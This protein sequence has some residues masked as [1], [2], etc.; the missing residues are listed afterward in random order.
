MASGTWTS[1]AT[2]GAWSLATNWSGSTIADG[3]GF[4]ANFA[5]NITAT[6]TIDTTIGGGW[7]GTI[8]SIVFSD[9][10]AS[11]SAWTLGTQSTI[12]LGS[13][14]TITTT[15]GATINGILAG[16]VSGLTKTGAQTLT[17]SGVNTFSGSI[18]INA[19]TLSVT[20]AS[21]L[22]SNT[23][24]VVTVTSG[25]VLSLGASITGS[26]LTPDISGTGIAGVNDGA[27]VLASSSISANIGAI[28]LGAS[29]KIRASAS[30][31]LASSIL[32]ASGRDL[33][34]QVVPTSTGTFSGAIT[35]AG[36]LIVGGTAGAGLT[37]QTGT[38]T[39]SSLTNSYTG[40]TT[41]S[42]G[43]T[44][45]SGLLGN[46]SYAGAI[47][48]ASGATFSFTSTSNQTLSGG[49]SGLGTLTK[50]TGTSSILTLS[51]TNSYSVLNIQAGTVSV[52]SIAN[53]IGSGVS[54]VNVGLTGTSGTLRY[55]GSGETTSKVIN[56]AG[57]TTGGATIE[58][59]GSGALVFT[60][61]ITGVSA[62]G[63]RTLTLSGSNAGV[64]DFQGVIADVGAGA[65]LTAFTKAGVGY[66]KLSGVN[67]F[68]GVNAAIG[69]TVTGGQLEIPALTALGSGT[70]TISITS[71]NRNSSMLLS[72]AVTYPPTLSW[73]LSS[74]GS[75]QANS[76]LGAI[77]ASADSTIAGAVALTSPSTVYADTGNLT[78]SG[79]VTSTTQTFTSRAATGRTV[80]I[81]GGIGTGTA[82]VA[83]GPGTTVW[84]GN[85]ANTTTA[86]PPN[87]S[88][89][90]LR[91]TM[92]LSSG[93]FA[94]TSVGFGNSAAQ[95]GSSSSRY[96][97]TGGTLELSNNG[98]AGAVD[99]TGLTNTTA[100]S[101]N[102]GSG[103]VKLSRDSTAGSFSMTLGNT[104]SP[105][106]GVLTL[107]YAGTT[108]T[109]GTD[110]SII[111]SSFT[112]NAHQ[113]RIII[114]NGS[115]LVPAYFDANRVAVPMVYGSAQLNVAASQGSGTTISLVSSGSTFGA[116]NLTGDISAQ[117]SART[118]IIRFD[119]S[120]GTPITLAAGANLQATFIMDMGTGT[121]RTII[122]GATGA[123]LSRH[124]LGGGVQIGIWTENVTSTGAT[125]SADMDARYNAG[126]T[127]AG[128]GILSFTGAVANLSGINIAEGTFRIGSA[129]TFDSTF[130][131]ITLGNVYAA[132]GT[133][134]A[135]EFNQPGDVV[136]AG[137]SGGGANTAVTLNGGDLV[138]RNSGTTTFGGDIVLGGAQ[139]LKV[140]SLAATS[141][142][143]LQSFQGAFPFT[144]I[145]MSRGYISLDPQYGM[146]FTGASAPTI[147]TTGGSFVAIQ[148]QN[149]LS[150]DYTVT[151]GAVSVGAGNLRLS[152][153]NSTTSGNPYNTRVTLASLALTGDATANLLAQTANPQQ[154]MT[155]T[156]AT[157]GQP[158]GNGL[159][160]WN[161]SNI[162]FYRAA[163]STLAGASQNFTGGIALFDTVDVPVYGT[164]A[165]G[166][167]N[168][169][170][171]KG[172]STSFTSSST[173]NINVTGAQTAQTA[174]TM[175]SLRTSA[176]ITMLDATQQIKTDLVISASITVVGAAIV[177]GVSTGKLSTQTGP[178]YIN[179]AASLLTI[180]SDIVNNGGTATKLIFYGVQSLTL[181]GNN[182]YTGG[183]VLNGGAAAVILNSQTA[184]GTGPV[185]GNGTQGFVVGAAITAFTFGA[186]N[187]ITLNDGG[188]SLVASAGKDYILNG[189]ISGT[190][191]LYL[192]GAGTFT[193]GAVGTGNGA[194]RMSSSSTVTVNAAQAFTEYD[195]NNGSL[196]FRY[197]TGYTTDISALATKRPGNTY[198][199]DTNGQD[200]AWASSVGNGSTYVKVG[201]GTHTLGAE[202]FFASATVST[203]AVQ[204]GNV[205][206]LGYG[207]VTLSAGTVLQTLTA[208]GQNG[209]LTITGT[210]TNSA[211][212]TIR[213][214]G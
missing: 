92:T 147:T 163:G 184:L 38:V 185:I 99:Y 138:L 204:A 193:L 126:F 75:D 91:Q 3:S 2:S 189:A 48:I 160:V 134:V 37:S 71:T 140:K 119:S 121:A 213:I 174:Q 181:S 96:Q 22:G 31:T 100:I 136:V 131:A 81:T 25:A 133:T 98:A 85:A 84:A 125:I 61:N 12:T 212:G 68:S 57:N 157:T 161:G 200:I 87:V 170:A 156:G 195:F 62:S 197:G 210:L 176:N 124:N 26:N 207:N 102:R 149:G 178:L 130:G 53:N 51:G 82:L 145:E 90:A 148:A 205:A 209:K 190:G 73:S 135:A 41:V 58:N 151:L 33:T 8:G 19:G 115:V 118:Q 159:N 21:G 32:T 65:G 101:I 198:R 196:T 175:R 113:P 177:G 63:T 88:G 50:A 158:M 111:F 129:G 173:E 28:T 46:G 153:A 56:L 127:K 97:Y 214:G 208:G 18:T 49:I 15:T 171:A 105:T 17:L 154:A 66:W 116:Y 52:A 80:T 7:S 76:A 14:S 180:N 55:T 137:L 108:G 110:S 4:T 188:L 201:D 9:N 186:G 114:S 35:G 6:T 128:V 107:E 40:D 206:A 203:G 104:A 95:T 77:R 123:K 139:K 79:T 168:F 150:T 30:G 70:K 64:N 182:S 5:S 120:T 132:S 11:G 69:V 93:Q 44:T 152:L 194:L 187:T 143:F 141:E 89:G 146:T 74:T 54:T 36:A 78:I 94:H 23:A 179:T 103:K 27:V 42:T 155:V 162:A 67:T 45:V 112:A 191:D 10:G 144:A 1:V 59:N 86:G 34:L 165:A 72:G 142:A 166:D 164:G 117:V 60:S 167:V 39:L 13:L 172:A 20:N 43:T 109:I 211:G 83:Q 47:S 106:N 16:A 199:I 183:T 29:A 24:R 169:P 192:T 202:N 122:A